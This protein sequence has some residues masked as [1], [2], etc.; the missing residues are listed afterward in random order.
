MQRAVAD[1]HARGL[2]MLRPSPSDRGSFV[3]EERHGD[4][5]PCSLLWEQAFQVVV[6]Q[7]RPKTVGD[8]RAQRTHVW[9][10]CAWRQGGPRRLEVTKI[11]LRSTWVRRSKHSSGAPFAATVTAH[12]HHPFA[13]SWAA[14]SPMTTDGAWVWPRMIS[15]ITEASA[16]RRQWTPRTRSSG[17]T[18]EA[19]SSPIRAVD[20]G[21]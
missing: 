4:L 3:L 6:G 11:R 10:G 8:G 21:W 15:G 20:V 12:R 9:M 16:T 5:G 17:S 18:T 13:M 2:V 7:N 19:S 1:V 14:R